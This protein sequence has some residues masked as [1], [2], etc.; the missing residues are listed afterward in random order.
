[1]KET[2]RMQT[3][4]PFSVTRCSVQDNLIGGELPVQKGWIVEAY[5]IFNHLSEKYFDAPNEFRPER[6]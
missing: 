5:P 4:V 3:P 1:M 2:L 6:W